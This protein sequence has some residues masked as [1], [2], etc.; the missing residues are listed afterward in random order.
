MEK[1]AFIAPRSPLE[2]MG[3]FWISAGKN[4]WISLIS[5]GIGCFLMGFIHGISMG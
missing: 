4:H 2:N 1:A 5:D 3:E